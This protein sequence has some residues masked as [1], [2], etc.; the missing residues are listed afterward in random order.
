MK[1]NKFGTL[2]FVEGEGPRIEGWVVERTPEDP[3]D[4]TMEQLL[5]GFVLHWGQK[6]FEAACQSAAILALRELAAKPQ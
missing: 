5:L 1:I 3:E 6:K 2:T 4:A